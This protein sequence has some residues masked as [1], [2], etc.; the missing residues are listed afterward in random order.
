MAS[1]AP[2]GSRYRG[3]EHAG[4]CILQ[5]NADGF[6]DTDIS[7]QIPSKFTV[8]FPDP[9]DDVTGEVLKT[10]RTLTQ[11]E[12]NRYVPFCPFPSPLPPSVGADLARGSGAPFLQ[13]Y[14][15]FWTPEGKVSQLLSSTE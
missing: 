2:A 3:V 6:P 4:E 7:H 14:I 12:E 13:V 8:Q 5:Q 15:T 9:V 11:Q 10:S 1:H